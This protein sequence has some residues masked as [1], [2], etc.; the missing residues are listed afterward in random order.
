MSMPVIT[1]LILIISSARHRKINFVNIMLML[2]LLPATTPF[3]TQ[4]LGFRYFTMMN[5]DLQ[6]DYTL[7][8]SAI[9][10]IYIFAVSVWLGGTKVSSNINLTNGSGVFLPKSVITIVFVILII[11][12]LL[13][14]E[15]NTILNSGYGDIKSQNNPY[16]SLINQIF[17]LSAAIMLC[18]FSQQKRR[19]LTL[20]ILLLFVIIT[21][22]MSRRTLALALIILCFYIRGNKAMD[23]RAIIL[24]SLGAFALWLIGEVRSVGLVQY[25][26]GARSANYVRDTFSMAGGGANIFLSAMGIIDL[27][28][29]GN[30]KFPENF[31]IVM[32]IAGDYE[33]SIYESH[34]YM[35][36]GGMHLAAVLYWNL[37]VIGV[38]L[39]GLGLGYVS[40]IFHIKLV[41]LRN[42]SGGDYISMLSVGFV[43]TLPNTVWYHPVGFIK[44]FLAITI[45]YFAL[46]YVLPKKML[47]KID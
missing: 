17:N 30:L 13:F 4:A 26:A 8:I 15:S 19:H 40:K 47:P 3:F 23:V 21:L 22:M 43:L 46:K 35:Y 10:L 28:V 24:M 39:G 38:I 31:P 25:A 44:L 20:V 42:R 1:I 11:G 32:W 14:L 5:F 33:G 36:N 2:I 41:T 6:D 34:G 18:A 16:S 7:Q 29:S 9:F 37:G 45:C 12:F 27:H